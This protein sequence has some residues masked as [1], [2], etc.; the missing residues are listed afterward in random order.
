MAIRFRT[1][2]DE[3]YNSSVF[4]AEIG[5]DENL[6]QQHMRDECDVNVIM[7]RYQKTGD[8][9][10]LGQIAGEY[11]DFSDVFDYKS[12]L[13]RIYAAQD[14]F[15]ELPSSIRDKFQNDPAKFIDF[16]QN[17]ENQQELRDMGLAPPLPQNVEA[18]AEPKGGARTSSPPPSQPKGSKTPAQQSSDD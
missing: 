17:P 9:S 12:G 10:H 1:Q 18:S 8:I 6:V 14:L 15:L 7:A 4:A 16:A 2:Y 3:D 13:D 5:E 11:G